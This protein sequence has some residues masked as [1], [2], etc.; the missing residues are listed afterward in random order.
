MAGQW[1]A[2]IKNGDPRGIDLNLSLNSFLKRFAR[3]RSEG[4]G[5]FA[6]CADLDDGNWEWQR[7]QFS[8]SRWAYLFDTGLIDEGT[9]IRLREEIWDDEPA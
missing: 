7:D 9:A 2:D 5:P 6:H 1:F 3:T 8:Q 4:S